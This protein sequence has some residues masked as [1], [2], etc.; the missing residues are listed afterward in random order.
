[1]QAAKNFSKYLRILLK[2]YSG[3][4]VYETVKTWIVRY[5]FFVYFFNTP[6]RL[7]SCKNCIVGSG[8]ST[9]QVLLHVSGDAAGADLGVDGVDPL[10]LGEGR[11]GLGLEVEPAPEEVL[12]A[13]HVAIEE[14]LGLRVLH[15][16]HLQ[17]QFS[18]FVD[19]LLFFFLFPKMYS[20]NAF[21][22][23]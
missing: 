13:G 5:K 12:E 1:V 11:R 9:N 21:Y 20:L 22:A 10:H 7:P 23:L 2:I 16:H 17:K 15:R 18:P 19:R 4:V 3:M 14:V 8:V 6:Q